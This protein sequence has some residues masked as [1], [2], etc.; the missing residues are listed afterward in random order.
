MTDNINK[1]PIRATVEKVI[2]ILDKGV[3]G[4]CQDEFNQYKEMLELMVDYIEHKMKD[5]PFKMPPYHIT[6]WDYFGFTK[7]QWTD[8]TKLT[9]DFYGHKQ[10]S[11]EVH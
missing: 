2:H 5:E 1:S 8:L 3:E 7:E 9:E 4:L 6:P 10:P 11:Q